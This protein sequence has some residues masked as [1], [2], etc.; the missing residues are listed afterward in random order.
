MVHFKI[1]LSCVYQNKFPNKHYSDIFTQ[2]NKETVVN[3]K[4]TIK[5]TKF[6]DKPNILNIQNH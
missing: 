4:S 3:R 5:T 2:T 1:V 6:T